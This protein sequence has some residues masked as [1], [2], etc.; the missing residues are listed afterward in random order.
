[1]EAHRT[2]VGEGKAQRQRALGVLTMPHQDPR[3]ME[4]L[5]RIGEQCL[6]QTQSLLLGLSSS[7]FE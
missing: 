1:M 7:Q 6:I 5:E 2:G 4:K 3:G